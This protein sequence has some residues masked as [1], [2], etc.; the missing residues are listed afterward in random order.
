MTAAGP[1]LRRL[2]PLTPL[3]T[4]WRSA[5][6]VSALGV[7]AFRD[8]LDKI[9]WIW[10]ALQGD[11]E[12]SVLA[13]AVAIAAVVAVA[14]VVAAWLSWRVTGFAIVSD[15]G[16]R[17]AAT[18]LVHR[19][20]LVR[21]RSQVRLKRVQAVDVNQPLIPRLL[22]LAEVRLDMAAGEDA[23]AKLAYLPADE[24]WRL[25]EEI[26]RHT[27]IGGALPTGGSGDAPPGGPVPAAAP[28]PDERL[29]AQI[30]TSHLVRANLLDGVWVW[31]LLLL[32]LVALGVAPILWG[33]QAFGGALAA[34]VPVTIAIVVQVR[35]QVIGIFRDANFSLVRTPTGIRLS[36]GLTS[37]V[38]RTIEL[39]RIQAVRVEEPYLWRRLGWARVEVDVAGASGGDHAAALMPVA[40]RADALALVAEVTG[41]RLAEAHVV[42]A[43]RKAKR[44]D[45]LGF[46][47]MGVGLLPGGA[48]TR[49][50]RFRRTEFYVP[51][52]RVQSVSVAQG[53]LQRRLGLATV[54]LDL[55]VGARR[56]AGS[57]R[58]VSDAAA[59]VGELVKRARTHRLPVRHPDEPQ[60]LVRPPDE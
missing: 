10:H 37:T 12:V 48:V 13:K 1:A 23:S 7:S 45:P 3:L 39:D 18:L 25:R 17:A 47:Y 27:V 8:D 53:W 35:Q 6:L 58:D 40:D 19:G 30:S 32:W 29:V 31:G 60:P 54:Y 56:W 41:A 5:G 20:L 33:W 28:A 52:A 4:S 14:S 46:A 21:R 2:H 15:P 50:C 11:V 44:L 26:L 24:A 16:Q 55:P 42:P 51:Y 38:N 9:T 49:S 34:I 36:S 22:G 59:L 43:G 57:H